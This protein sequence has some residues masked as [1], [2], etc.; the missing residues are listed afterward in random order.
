MSLA[1]YS[2]EA[3]VRESIGSHDG[4]CRVRDKHADQAWTKAEDEQQLA[5]VHAAAPGYQKH[6]EGNPPMHVPPAH[7]DGFE[8][9]DFRVPET[10]EHVGVRSR[11]QNVF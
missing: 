10:L 5:G 1:G 2:T 11:I 8:L 3:V 6:L 4:G 7:K 9:L